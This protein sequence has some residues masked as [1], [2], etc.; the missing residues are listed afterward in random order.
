M[1]LRKGK[2]NHVIFRNKNKIKAQNFIGIYE[3]LSFYILKNR[4]VI[5][6]ISSIS[7]S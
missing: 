5:I 1:R 2:N 3:V 4:N 7:T 6:E